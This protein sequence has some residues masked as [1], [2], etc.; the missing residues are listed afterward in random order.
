L[1]RSRLGQRAIRQAFRR[2]PLPLAALL[3]AGSLAAASASARGPAV[4]VKVHQAS[5]LASPYLQLAGSAG[6]S[7]R[8]GALDLVNPTANR[9]A[10][11]L[12]PVDGITTNT[13]GSAYTLADAGK[14]GPTIWLRLGRRR[15]VLGPHANQSVS[16][17]VAVPRS[18]APGDYLAGVSV[19]ALGQTQRTK[20][21][22]GVTIGEI[23][24]YAI[25]VQ[26]K[27]PG[28][29]H[30]AVKFTGA[31]VTRE[32]A[33]L[34]FLLAASNTGNVILKGVHGWVR[35]THGNRVVSAATIQP[36]TFV[37]QTN[38]SYPVP[39]PREQPTP[40]TSYRVRAALYFAG[41]VARLDTIVR[42]S[43]AA[44]VTQQ[45]Y[46]GRTLPSSTIPWLWIA[47][48]LIVLAA[49]A[50]I[51]WKLY[52]RRRPMSRAAGRRLLDRLLG[53]AGNLPVSIALVSADRGVIGTIA[54]VI[55]PRLRRSDRACDLGQEG[56]LVICPATSHGAASALRDDLYEHCARRADLADVP[57]EI[58]VSTA[59]EPTTARE[60]LE[61][62][63]ATRR[64]QPQA[65]VRPR[66]RQTAAT[67]RQ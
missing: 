54:N 66:D 20:A 43:H 8:A 38:I 42:F 23:D 65:P 7:V 57:V 58:T 17:S 33:G 52:Q 46:G 28:A 26:V 25:G 31:T 19:E 40:G 36:G 37:S 10:V 53:A 56:L 60:L 24:R 14:H 3:F 59:D 63:Q 61:R 13:L 18:T 62:L 4:I 45:N 55:R 2:L 64:H 15:V 5:G 22:R 9:V 51:G 32:P 30:P 50:A 35:V 1:Q 21:S 44:A 49:L 6:S 47:L 48:A 39:T 29:R 27:L 16:V 12:D 11:R 34:T 41:G 67:S